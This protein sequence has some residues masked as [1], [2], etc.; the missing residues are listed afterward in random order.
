M[1]SGSDRRRRYT[2]DEARNLF[3]NMLDESDDDS[4]DSELVLEPQG[5]ASLIES[6]SRISLYHWDEMKVRQ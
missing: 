2:A 5:S 1:A 3:Q 6:D 4:S